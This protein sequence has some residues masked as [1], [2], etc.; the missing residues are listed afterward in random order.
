MKSDWWANILY[1]HDVSIMLMFV[2]VLSFVMNWEMN[3]NARIRRIMEI[4]ALASCA[5]VLV[6]E[7]LR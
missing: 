4:V 3:A 5:V 6:I 7:A 1:Q 2:L